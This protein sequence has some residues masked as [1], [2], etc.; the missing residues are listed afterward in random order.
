MSER[1]Q[2]IETAQKFINT[3]FSNCHA[4]VLAGSVVRGEET[5][6]SDLD[7]V[8][9]DQMLDHAYRES[10]LFEGWPIEVFVHNLSS[11][12]DFFE[13]DCDQAR[14]SL[15]RM[16]AEGFVL[17]DKGI[18]VKIKEEAQN[19]LQKGPAKWTTDTI[20]LKRYFITDALDDLS[21]ANNRGEEIFIASHLAEL[22]SE[23]YLRTNGQWVGNSKWIVRSLKQFDKEFANRFVDIFDEFY[24]SGS[25]ENINHNAIQKNMIIQFYMI[26]KISFIQMIF[27]F[28]KSGPQSL[29]E[30][31]L[32][33]PAEL[34]E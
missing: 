22:L 5:L 17:K 34:V 11:Y 29:K 12:K 1:P 26:R 21:G 33:S 7:I 10:T 18:L 32:I 15:P 30:R 3:Y 2:P 13:S 4:A 31:Y 24:R 6:T 23:F 16:V 27:C 20:D 19:L 8:V 28:Y 25:K 9:F 14:P